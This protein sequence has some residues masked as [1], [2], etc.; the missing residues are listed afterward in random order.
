M[1][2]AGAAFLPG[3]QGRLLP[4]SVPF[5]FFG[6]A[7]VFHLA[8][9]MLLFF[10]AGQVP[11]FAGGL[12]PPLAALHVITIGVLTLTA[13]GAAAQLLPVATRQPMAAVWPIRLAAAL[14]IPGVPVLVYGMWFYDIPT[15][16]AGGTLCAAGM[17]LAGIVL[18]A[19]L[20]RAG[21]MPVVLGFARIAV[22][23]LFAVLAIGA[24]LVA[25]YMGAGVSGHR[26]YVLLHLLFGGYVFMGFLALGFSYV[27]VPMF[28][29][30]PPAK[31]RLGLA[32][33][34]LCGAGAAAAIPG[35]IWSI[36]AVVT[37]ALLAG[38]AGA[39]LYLLAMARAM[40]GR[41]KKRLGVSFLLVRLAWVLLPVSLL[42]TLAAHL[43]LIPLGAGPLVVFALIYGWLLTFL[44][45]VLQRI[46]P[47]LASMHSAKGG[48][49]PPLV[50]ELSARPP[51]ILHAV[52]HVAALALV[53][54][55]IA[56]QQTVLIQIGA[57]TGA[58]GAAA[59]LYFGV[60]VVSR[61]TRRRLKAGKDGL[62]AAS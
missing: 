15:L 6:A 24:L 26:T 36:D 56:A 9:W 10:A 50:S 62:E 52:C 22:A 43:S 41:M 51:M 2:A 14:L 33:L 53:A 35:L 49:Q 58:A 45:G 42:V 48:G 17:L 30:S 55:G 38:L 8:G 18:G 5:S 57:A 23:G 59:F 47:F 13:I 21:G 46:M 44:M 11:Y 20:L 39:G 19:N 12:G 7:V 60:Q 28:G 32:A 31:T 16:A 4:P 54:A 25:N 27:L 37:A 61:M 3:A 29:L 34:G 40:G 1:T